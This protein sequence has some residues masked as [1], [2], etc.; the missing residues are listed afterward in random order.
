MMQCRATDF[1]WY[2]KGLHTGLIMDN[3]LV[4]VDVTVAHSGLYSC[5]KKYKVGLQLIGTSLLKTSGCKI[6]INRII[7]K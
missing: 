2:R 3:F 5:Y 7:S 6:I 4:I 1:F